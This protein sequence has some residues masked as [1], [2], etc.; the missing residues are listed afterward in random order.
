MDEWVSTERIEKLD[1][2]IDEEK[3]NN[4][5][6]AGEIVNS[7]DEEYEGMDA[8]ARKEHE[9]ATKIKTVTTIKFG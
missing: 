9:E 7:S 2:F 8:N 5:K 4:Q 3:I 6:K 1:E